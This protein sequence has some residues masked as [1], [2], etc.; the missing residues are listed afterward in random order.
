MRRRYVDSFGILLILMSCGCNSI[1]GSP[2]FAFPNRLALPSF[3]KNKEAPV[4]SPASLESEAE[5]PPVATES[6]REPLVAEGTQNNVH[7][8]A[9][10]A[11]IDT[12]LKDLPP[13]ER[14]EWVSYLNSVDAK[15]VPYILK[16]RRI[17]DPV[18]PEKV[19]PKEKLVVQ[20]PL[21]DEEVIAET[22]EKIQT[23]SGSGLNTFNSASS[24]ATLTDNSSQDDSSQADVTRELN[25]SIDNSATGE[26][27]KPEDADA[28][29]DGLEAPGPVKDQSWPNRLK[30]LAD[31]KRIW[32][33][34]EKPPTEKEK[35]ANH[36][37]LL[38]KILGGGGTVSENVE[39]TEPP[40]SDSLQF[41]LNTA[42]EPK[43]TDTAPLRIPRGS[44]L[45]EDEL[46]KLISLLEAETS[47]LLPGSAAIRGDVRKQ[48]ALRMLYLVGD[49]PQL[50]QQAIPGISQAEQEFWTAMFVGLSDYLDEQSPASPA[51]RATMTIAQLRNAAHHLQEI[52]HLQ[53]KNVT[54][55]SKINSFGNYDQFE[56]N[57]FNIGQPV[58]VYT[59]VRNF[60]SEPTTDGYYRTKLKSVVEI[61]QGGTD[62]KLVDRNAFP[63]TE[64]LCRTPRTDYYHSYRIDMPTHLVPGPHVLKLTVQDDLSGKITTETIN[65]SVY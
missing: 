34:G 60:Q 28:P 7:D 49:Q 22:N 43:P 39:S 45:W 38:P 30:S 23:V 36:L 51:E 65:F 6:G 53:L 2:R 61:Y 33:N 15:M 32:T 12:E 63:P 52:S 4:S 16:S 18:A 8:P 24:E 1:G 55:C 21:S 56:V 64:D 11:L 3:N 5:T 44:E 10:Q 37:S 46:D 62:G 50:A 48:V 29:V 31:P 40:K 17:E 26:E 35:T 14:M 54:F 25:N 42:P 9:T 59:E 27:L 58:L 13:E 47:S 57:E 41:D 19:A 20:N